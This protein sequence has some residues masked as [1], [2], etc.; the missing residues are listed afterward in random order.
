M[1]FDGNNDNVLIIKVPKW[2]SIL[3]G[4]Q[5]KQWLNLFTHKNVCITRQK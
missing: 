4:K 3:Y 2:T 1:I 5:W